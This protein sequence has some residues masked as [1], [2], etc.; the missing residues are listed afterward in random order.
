[1]LQTWHLISSRS[2]EPIWSN[3]AVF[4]T[5]YKPS[6][7]D[8]PAGHDQIHQSLT[9][10]LNRLLHLR[11][12]QHEPGAI[13]DRIVLLY[14]CEIRSPRWLANFDARSIASVY[15]IDLMNAATAE[16]LL[17]HD[18][19]YV[20]VQYELRMAVRPQQCTYYGRTKKISK[21]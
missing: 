13:S 4:N 3:D 14:L 10:C 15:M 18:L 17:D 11:K 6:T 1:M 8:R 16:L 2:R 12:Y 9:Y 7:I 21:P 5:A 20:A 19:R